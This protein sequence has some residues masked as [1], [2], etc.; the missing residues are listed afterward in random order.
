MKKCAECGSPLVAVKCSILLDA[1]GEGRGTT[2]TRCERKLYFC[3]NCF[4]DHP[5][6][7]A[8]DAFVWIFQLLKEAV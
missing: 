2:N 6:E 5:L 8:D 7:T 1:R 3:R 4:L